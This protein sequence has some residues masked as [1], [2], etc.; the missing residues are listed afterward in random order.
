MAKKRKSENAG[1]DEVERT[2]YTTFCTA[3]NSISQLYTQAQHQQKLAFQAGERHTVE[4]LYQWLHREHHAGSNISTAE[5]LNYLQNELDGEEMTMSPGP[6]FQNQFTP[7]QQQHQHQQHLHQQQQQQQQ[8]QTQQ[9]QQLLMS[10]QQQAPATAVGY[11]GLGHLGRMGS[12]VDQSKI[13]VFTGALSSPNRR[14]LP[15]FGINQGGFVSAN[16]APATQARRPNNGMEQHN[17]AAS[18]EQE[19]S[20]TQTQPYN[21]SSDQLHNQSVSSSI[22]E[23]NQAPAGQQRE[24]HSFGENDSS[25]DMHADGIYQDEFYQ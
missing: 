13:S 19:S 12:T 20:P 1:L 10:N 3:A 5:I 4:K 18:E 7:Q 25:M 17:E 11:S 24:S 23:Y 8:Q 14:C 16:N 22:Y 6:Q 21:A 2:L 9:P 15:P